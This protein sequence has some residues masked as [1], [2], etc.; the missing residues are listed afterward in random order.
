MCFDP[1]IIFQ[2]NDDDEDVERDREQEKQDTR[3][4]MCVRES[5]REVKVQE[6]E[7]Y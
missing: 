3:A 1:P 2:H 5:L 7:A 6:R 4:Q